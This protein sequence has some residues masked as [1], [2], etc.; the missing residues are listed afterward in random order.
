MTEAKPSKARQGC[1]YRTR[2]LLLIN[3]TGQYIPAGVVVDLS[4]CE[5]A[6]L[7]LLL[8]RGLIETADPS[9]EEPLYNPPGE[10]ARTVRRKPCPCGR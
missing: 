3:A 9:P 7:R 1:T 2:T 4:D 5:D 10:S 6:S 8:Q